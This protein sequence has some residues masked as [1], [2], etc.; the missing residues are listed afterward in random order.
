EECIELSPEQSAASDG[1]DYID[2]RGDVLPFI[3]LRE[4]FEADNQPPRRESVVVVSYAGMRAGLVVDH[5][6][7]ELQTVIKPLGKLFGNNRSIGGFTI[8]GSGAVAL[9]LDIAG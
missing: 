1:E 7:G 4:L 8:L 5:L 9:I 3:R 6:L 2:L